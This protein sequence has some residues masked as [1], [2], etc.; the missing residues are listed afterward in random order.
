[1][2]ITK[3]QLKQIIKEELEMIMQESSLNIKEI[4]EI[5]ERN[6]EEGTVDQAA[7]ELD[8]YTADQIA[9]YAG[10]LGVLSP[11]KNAFI[12]AI[13]REMERDEY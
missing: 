6:M 12:Q 3:E 10:I 9:E 5:I 7:Y 8:H 11:G 2:Q 13:E 1:M 4:D